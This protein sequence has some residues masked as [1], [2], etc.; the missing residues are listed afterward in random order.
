VANRFKRKSADAKKKMNELGATP[1]RLA[2]LH[3]SAAGQG[4]DLRIM[5]QLRKRVRMAGLLP[6]GGLVVAAYLGV[7][8]AARSEEPE[9]EGGEAERLLGEGVATMLQ[10]LELLLKTVPQYAAPEVMPNGDII[11]RRLHPEEDSE[12]GTEPDEQPI[13]PEDDSTET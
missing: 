6:I 12:D 2:S 13:D 1:A 11:I 7:A 4:K 3:P 9:A 5:K 8:S 10:A